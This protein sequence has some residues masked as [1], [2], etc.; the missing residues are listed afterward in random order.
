[1]ADEGFIPIE[2]SNIKSSKMRSVISR[3]NSFGY[4]C[5]S[6]PVSICQYRK[7]FACNLAMPQDSG[8]GA[9]CFSEFNCGSVISGTIITASETDSYYKN[10]NNGI[11]SVFIDENS[12]VTDSTNKKSFGFKGPGQC[13]DGA[14]DCHVANNGSSCSFCIKSAVVTCASQLETAKNCFYYL[15]NSG[16]YTICFQDALT[17]NKAIVCQ[18]VNVGL[19]KGCQ[20]YCCVQKV[21]NSISEPFSL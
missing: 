11:I 7:R 10:K 12:V 8:G 20:I 9:I 21:G 13:Y 6:K 19:G 2:Q 15:I 4:S 18:V 17:T 5:K 14:P 1:M 16:N 3:S